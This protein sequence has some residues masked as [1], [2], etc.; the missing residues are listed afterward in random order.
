[1]RKWSS[2]LC[3][4]AMATVAMAG[5]VPDSVVQALANADKALE[6]IVAVPP[7]DRNFQNTLGALDDVFTRLD[8]DT[9]LTIFMQNVS[10]DASTR[11][12]SRAANEAVSNWLIEVGKNEGLYRAIKEYADRKPTLSGEEA[13]FLDFTMRDYR[14]SGMS[15]PKE[16]RDRLKSLEVEMSKLSIDFE[17]NISEDASIVPLFPSELKGVPKDVVDRQAVSAGMVLFSLDG[18]SYGGLMDYC[19]NAQ[20]R[21]K[22]WTTYRRRAGKN[23]EVLE[24]LLK[25]R[26][27]H[28]KILGFKNTVDERV[29]TR[30]AKNSETVAKFYAEL[31]PVVNKKAKADYQ[32]FLNL[33]RKFTKNKNAKFD[34]WDYAFYKNLLRNQKYNVDS[35]KVSEYF[36]ISQVVSGLFKVSED[37]FGIVM[38]DVTSEAQKLGLPLWHTDVKLYQLSDKATG[39]LL[40][41][42]YTDLYP[43]PNKYNHAAC[44]G[45]RGRKV[46]SNGKTDLPLAALVCNFTKPTATKP[47]LLPHDEV[48]T[49]FHEFGH[50]LHQ[51]LTETTLGRFSG[52]S[53][54]QDFVEAPSQMLENWV[55]EPSVLK[56]FAKHYKTGQPMPSTLVQGMRAARTL[57]SGIETQGQLYLGKMDQAF[58]SVASGVVDTSKV[59]DQVYADTMVYGPVKG[60]LFH[61]AFG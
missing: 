25:L 32:E 10:T 40:G 52:T 55:W 5:Q 60:T 46:W 35:E 13:R 58:H 34:P 18:P 33:K 4:A 38:T 22:V 59:A 9:S 26:S 44:W 36:P 7:G 50:G 6:A 27:E 17:T 57:G 24:K 53:V 45:L 21:Q 2:F 43:R 39:R 31:Q 56:L 41:H 47:S 30:M 42:M 37:L 20:T 14:L 8:Q 61:A 12:S 54:A 28:A 48:E 15:L 1:M 3:L 11:E 51:I 16:Q 19:Q 49:F 23:V 29:A